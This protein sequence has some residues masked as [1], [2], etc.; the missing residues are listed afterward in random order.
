MT[1]RGHL[2]LSWQRH[3]NSP[4]CEHRGV[5]SKPSGCDWSERFESLMLPN[6]HFIMLSNTWTRRRHSKEEAR[7]VT[8]E[9]ILGRK[10][11]KSKAN[12]GDEKYEY[13][14]KWHNFSAESV[15]WVPREILV[16]MGHLRMVQRE[17]EKQA[18]AHGLV[19]RPLTQPQVEEH[20]AGFGLDSNLASHTRTE[21]LAVIRERG[22]TNMK[23]L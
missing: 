16:E 2:H 6:M 3:A 20:L 5:A 15:Q 10:K 19:A 7:A 17:D 21:R 23:T 22:I 18:A 13:S 9:Q 11:S 12:S 8:A 1:E 4:Q 14:V